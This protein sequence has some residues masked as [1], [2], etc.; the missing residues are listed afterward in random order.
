M[1]YRLVRP[2]EVRPTYSIISR[3]GADAV[4]GA[5][6]AREGREPAFFYIEQAATI[7]R[8]L[9]QRDKEAAVLRRRLAYCP[10]ERR[11]GSRIKE[12]F[13]KLSM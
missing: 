11:K 9:G 3:P 7:H 1:R 8:K 2:S 6:E 4:E 12:R 13:D 10:P 5:E